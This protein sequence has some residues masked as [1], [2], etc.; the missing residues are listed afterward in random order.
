[1]FL[2]LPAPVQV[3]RDFLY[4]K[5]L[6]DSKLKEVLLAITLPKNTTLSLSI[7]FCL[8]FGCLGCD[9]CS[10]KGLEW[11]PEKPKHR[12]FGSVGE[13]REAILTFG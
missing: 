12:V 9:T 8:S 10:S 1:M 4:L 3:C 5:K 7:L 6:F 13:K 2:L 11:S